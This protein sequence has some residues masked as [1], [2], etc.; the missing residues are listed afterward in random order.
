MPADPL[1]VSV[2]RGALGGAK[3][4]LNRET[5][6]RALEAG[7]RQMDG[8]DNVTMQLSTPGS[9]WRITVERTRTS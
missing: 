6:Y 9:V 1:T 5:G 3:Q 4:A 7:E 8:P 2:L